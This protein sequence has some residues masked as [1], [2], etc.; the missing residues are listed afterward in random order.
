MSPTCQARREGSWL[1]RSDPPPRW[2][3]HWVAFGKPVR[4]SVRPSAGPGW[5]SEGSSPK[6]SACGTTSGGSLSPGRSSGGER[7]Q[8]YID[9]LNYRLCLM[10]CSSVVWSCQQLIEIV[11]IDK[12]TLQSG[13]MVRWNYF[14]V[15]FGG[16]ELW[17][18]LFL[19]EYWFNVYFC[20]LNR[21][22]VSEP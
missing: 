18:I 5:S 19:S 14:N 17:H 12:E 8:N 6:H 3:N 21:S 10:L 1:H 16:Y 4:R 7:G 9:T 13:K 15:C 2:G 20:S 11:H 22:A